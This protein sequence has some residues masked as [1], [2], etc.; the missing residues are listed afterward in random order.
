MNK[1]NK[2]NKGFTL[3]ELIAV[4]A[5]LLILSVLAVVQFTN[6]TGAAEDA[7]TIADA[8]A[9]ASQLNISNSLVINGSEGEGYINQG[10]LTNIV[11]FG[12]GLIVWT[13]EANNSLVRSETPFSITIADAR[14]TNRVR[15]ALQYEFGIWTVNEEALRD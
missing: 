7:A 8:R 5:V 9:V 4:I 1:I 13:L 10:N 12:E 14:R 6:L 11:T 2:S 3:V 15:D